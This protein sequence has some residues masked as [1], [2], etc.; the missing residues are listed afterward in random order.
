M[1]LLT[2]I[3]MLFLSL[4]IFSDEKISEDS[5]VVETA[6]SKHHIAINEDLSLNVILRYPENFQ[7]QINLMQ[8]RLTHY[9]GLYEP[10][11]TLI[12]TIDHP[13]QKNGNLITQE[14]TFILS[15]QTI[16]KHFLSLNLVSFSSNSKEKRTIEI[17]SEVF[18]IEV[19]L[20]QITFDLNAFIEPPMK[21][22]KE[23]PITI[24]QKNDKN[25]LKNKSLIFLET[26]KNKSFIKSRSIPWFS[27]T[28]M[29]I[30]ALVILLIRA[31]PPKT[32]K[33][34]IDSLIQ[35]QKEIKIKQELKKASLKP[36]QDIQEGT[37]FIEHIDFLLRQYLENQYQF[38]ALALTTQELIKKT[39]EIKEL[40]SPLKNKINQVFQL[41]DQ[42]KFA[43][44][45]P[46]L[47]ICLEVLRTVKSF[48]NYSNP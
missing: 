27:L 21:L 30:V 9:S 28:S 35:E 34:R 20:P 38:P 3:L 14:I 23:L 2:F 10:P 48:A 19:Y 24:S 26:E 45:I 1:K 22:T 13:I 32:K 29:V 44:V 17:P 36:P 5:F 47:E 11:F 33:E 7:P 4:P 8:R 25:Y 39:S 31:L 6:I 37:I 41:A 18:S 42:I 43:H 15:P 12:Q 46:P 40:P 16:G